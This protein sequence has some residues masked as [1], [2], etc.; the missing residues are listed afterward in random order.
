MMPAIRKAL[1]LS[2]LSLF[3][4]CIAV[5]EAGPVHDGAV[6]VRRDSC[7][8]PPGHL[9]PPGECRIWYR[10]VP[11]GQQPPPEDCHAVE[12]HVP[13]DACLVYGE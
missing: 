12:R 5:S 9:P 13:P 6:R 10:G 8:V 3:A 11:P 4:G 7:E 2:A 1:V